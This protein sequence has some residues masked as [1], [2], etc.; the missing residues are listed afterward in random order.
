MVVDVDK[1][2]TPESGLVFSGEFWPLMKI[3]LVNILLTIVTLGIWHFWATTRNRRYLW[4][5]L[6]LVDE[7]FSWMGTGGQ[8]FRGWLI[9]I[10]PFSAVSG[11]IYLLFS[12]ELAQVIQQILTMVVVV[13]GVPYAVYFATRYR[14]SHSEWCG[15]RG[16][17]AGSVGS[18]ALLYFGYLLLLSITLGLTTPLF[19]RATTRRIIEMA[20]F[21]NQPFHFTPTGSLPW[22]TFI[23]F[24]CELANISSHFSS[25]IHDSHSA[26][27]R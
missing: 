18:F 23:L 21:G 8:L 25:A 19:T 5:H 1:N 27:V 26:Y 10:V 3:H 9:V 11:L 13:I 20:R 2:G 4:S 6:Y 24:C 16:G 17:L 7:G 14:L 12:F 22:L 15:I